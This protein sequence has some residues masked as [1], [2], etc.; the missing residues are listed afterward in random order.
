M[1]VERELEIPGLP[2]LPRNLSV[3]G[4]QF[5]LP[6]PKMGAASKETGDTESSQMKA[7]SSLV[8]T[9][10][11]TFKEAEDREKKDREQAEQEAEQKEKNEQLLKKQKEEEEFKK[12]NEF[13]EAGMPL[14]YLPE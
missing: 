13:R 9:T 2:S 3:E 7:I 4:A 6:G 11:K 12:R 10:V 14:Q 1:E 5:A 8:K